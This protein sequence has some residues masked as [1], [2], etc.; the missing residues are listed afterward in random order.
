MNSHAIFLFLASIGLVS[1]AGRIGVDKASKHSVS[2]E[3]SAAFIAGEAR[4]AVEKL[5]A[6]LEEN[7]IYPDIGAAYSRMLRGKLA[8]GAYAR[9]PS[10]EEFANVVTADLQAVNREGHLKLMAPGAQPPGQSAAGTSG[11]GVGKAGWLA[12]GVA[13]L[14]IHGFQGNRSEYTRLMN[15]LREVLDRF[16]TAQSVIIDARPY[17]GGALEET[18]IMASYFFAKPTILLHIDIRQDVEKSG[19]SPLGE[20]ATLRRISGPKGVVRREQVAVPSK[21]ATKLRQ[22]RIF[23]LT[24]RATASGG[25]GFTLSMKHTGRATIIGEATAGAGHLGR[26]TPLTGGY[27]SFNPVGRPFDPATGKGREQTGVDPH[28]KV[29]AEKA[30]DEALHRAGVDPAMAKKALESLKTD[31]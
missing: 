18:D 3:Q 19:F 6:L 12:P 21:A 11:S 22:A 8:S 27:R 30:L 23:L 25:E 2:A 20:S 29:P 13:Y 9:F 10:S 15:R 14:S 4:T 28:V 7:F 26:T 17:V 24:S 31:W 1:N 16:S 5:A